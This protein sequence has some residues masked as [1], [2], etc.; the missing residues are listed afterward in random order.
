MIKWMLYHDWVEIVANLEWLI[1]LEYGKLKF[2]NKDQL[3]VAFLAKQTPQTKK[4]CMSS[5]RTMVYPMTGKSCWVLVYSAL[6]V[7]LFSGT[8]FEDMIA[9]LTWPCTLPPGWSV[10]W[11]GPSAGADHPPTEWR[12]SYGLYRCVTCFARRLLLLL[13]RQWHLN[14]LCSLELHSTSLLWSW[15][16][17]K[18]T[19]RCKLWYVWDDLCCNI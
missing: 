13:L 1:Q 11:D 16:C 5:Y 2:E 15:F 3:L 6:F 4:S 18:F 10:E 14:N 9:S 17:N 19:F 7:V 8:N 12:V